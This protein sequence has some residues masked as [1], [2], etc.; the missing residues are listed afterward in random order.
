[1]GYLHEGHLSLV[2]A[3]VDGNDYTAAT[4]FVN[5]AQFG[6]N[7]DLARYPRDEDRDLQLLEA[8]D[9]DAVFIPT[10]DEIYPAGFDTW[11]GVEHLTQCLEGASRP[12]H[13]RG[14]TTVVLKLLQ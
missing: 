11:V 9:T 12:T 5:P 2:H 1:M 3:S 13:F 7:E 8:A 14:V 6:P 4:I 10:T